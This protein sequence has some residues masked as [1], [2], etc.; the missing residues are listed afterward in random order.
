MGYIIMIDR[1]YNSKMEQE[2]EIC[3]ISEDYVTQLDKC[4]VVQSN[5][6]LS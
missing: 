4:K 2:L 3:T 1:S 6:T 5:G